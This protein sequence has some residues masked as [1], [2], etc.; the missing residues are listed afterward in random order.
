MRRRDVVGRISRHGLRQVRGE[1]VV[2]QGWVVSRVGWKR[3]DEG[4]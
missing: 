2:G 1:K 3:G 4:G